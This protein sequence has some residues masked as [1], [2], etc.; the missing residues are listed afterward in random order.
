MQSPHDW[1]KSSFSSV[2]GECVEVRMGESVGM[3]D[4]K[5]PAGAA[6]DFPR[7]VWSDFIQTLKQGSV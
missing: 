1:V 5:N 7:D 4:S 6:L 2:S 3:R